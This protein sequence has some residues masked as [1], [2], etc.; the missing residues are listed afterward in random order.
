M[1]SSP[2]EVLYEELF[3][4]VSGVPRNLASIGWSSYKGSSAEEVTMGTYKTHVTKYPG[5]PAEPEGFLG[6]NNGGESPFET[7]FAMVTDLSKSIDLADTVITWSMGNNKKDLEVRLLIKMGGKW[8]ASDEVFSNSVT[9][10]E[11]EKF[12]EASPDEVTQSLKFSP[13]ASR[14]RQFTLDPGSSMALGGAS[15]GDLSAKKVTGI[16][17]YVV[18]PSAKIFGRLDT[19][20]ISSAQ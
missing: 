10:N 18:T 6:V 7:T 14:W 15:G 3:T 17:F 16:G 8:Y 19:L 1:V 20:R 2:A 9:F 5:N 13:K 12:S 11:A 4:N